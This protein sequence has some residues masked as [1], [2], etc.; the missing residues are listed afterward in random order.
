MTVA[1]G[2]PGGANLALTTTEQVFDLAALGGYEV[3]LVCSTRDWQFSFAPASETATAPPLVA[4][5]SPASLTTYIADPVGA[6]VKI[7]REVSQPFTKLVA[8]SLV[9][10]GTLVIK[11]IRRA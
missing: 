9:G 1:K 3:A 8:K 11:P 6:T 2:L 7:T 10:T 5:A 4:T